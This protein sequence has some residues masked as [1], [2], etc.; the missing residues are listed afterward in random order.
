QL[1]RQ[2]NVTGVVLVANAGSQ[3]RLNNIK[4]QVSEDGEKWTDVHQFGPFQ[5]NMM[6]VDLTEKLPLAKYVRILRPGGPEFFHLNGIY[7]YGNQAA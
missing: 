5:G 3:F 7:I 6:R 4:V 1:P 2:V